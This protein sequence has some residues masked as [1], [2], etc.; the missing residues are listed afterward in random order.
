VVV[1]STE[2]DGNILKIRPRL[3]FTAA[4]VPTLVDALASALAETD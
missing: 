2:R 4:H 3:A 1:G